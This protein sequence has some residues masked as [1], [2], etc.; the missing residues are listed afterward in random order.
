M[1]NKMN[2]EQFNRQQWKCFSHL[3]IPVYHHPYS[4]ICLSEDLKSFKI[5]FLR[6][7]VIFREKLE[8]IQKNPDF[9]KIY[10]KKSILI[11]PD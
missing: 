2:I 5:I 1:I 3:V 4:K 9:F 6:S 11:H 10:L 7:S 8:K